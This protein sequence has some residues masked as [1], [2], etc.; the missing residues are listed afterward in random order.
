MV[1]GQYCNDVC[2][3]KP[4]WSSSQKTFKTFYIR[5]FIKRILDQHSGSANLEGK[6]IFCITLWRSLT[7]N[8]ERL[9]EFDDLWFIKMLVSTMKMINSTHYFKTLNHQLIRWFMIH[10]KVQIRIN[11]CLLILKNMQLCVDQSKSVT[12][13]HVISDLNLQS[14][15]LSINSEK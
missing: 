9:G 5:F 7:K 3:S 10:K 15:N 2:M 4:I 12:A 13:L 11:P 1:P 8:L 6:W 14:G